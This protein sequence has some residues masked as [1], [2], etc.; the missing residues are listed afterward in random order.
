[1]KKIFLV[2]AFCAFSINVSADLILDNATVT[3]GGVTPDYDNSALT[4][5]LLNGVDANDL[6]NTGLSGINNTGLFVE[7][8][9]NATNLG[10]ALAINPFGPVNTDFNS[11]RGDNTSCAVNSAAGGVVTTGSLSVRKG[12]V[13]GLAKI[14]YQDNCYGYTPEDNQ[15]SGTVSIDFNPIIASAAAL[16]GTEMGIDYL[17]FYWAT[18]D[19][20]NTFTFRSD[21]LDVLELTGSDLLKAV[22]GL[23][24]GR[25]G[26]YVNV[27]FNNGV[28]FDE[29][30]VVST[31]RAAEFDNI[32]NRITAVP[33]PSTL[34]IFAL[35][36]MGLASRRFKK[37]A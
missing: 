27:F 13:G 20:Y 11:T 36:L 9:D 8:F 35:G 21:G 12:D 3:F 22:S 16:T 6:A 30:E 15:R 31:G 18:I 37:Q 24:R 7:T 17:G 33:E 1:M 23:Q 34:A 19:T 10:T 26:Q 28:F 4:S 29:L 32:V 5:A 14:G 2:G 25:D